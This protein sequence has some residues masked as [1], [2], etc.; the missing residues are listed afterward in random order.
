MVT[1]EF[2]LCIVTATLSVFGSV[3]LLSSRFTSLRK[4]NLKEATPKRLNHDV[5]FMVAL[6]DL[7]NS[8]SYVVMYSWLLVCEKC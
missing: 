3:A 2:A 1:A 8:F 4:G 6:N 5:I 7:I